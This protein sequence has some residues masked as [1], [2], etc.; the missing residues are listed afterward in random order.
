MSWPLE[1]ALQ[2]RNTLVKQRVS[3]EFRF[4]HKNYAVG[5]IVFVL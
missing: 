3:V 1:G 2:R 4:Q 5:S